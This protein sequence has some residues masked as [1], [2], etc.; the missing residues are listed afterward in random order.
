LGYN[1]TN[2]YVAIYTLAV[3]GDFSGSRG[4]LLF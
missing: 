3:T 4:G 2:G 1:G